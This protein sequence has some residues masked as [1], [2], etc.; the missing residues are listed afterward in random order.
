MTPDDPTSPDQPSYSVG[1]G[2]PP[3]HSRFKPG[4]SGNPRGRKKGERSVKAVVR[5]V[6]NEKVPVRTARGTRKMTKLEALVH[7]S[8]NNA[9]KGNAKATDQILKLMREAG[10][11][12]ERAEV[13]EAM[14]IDELAAEDRAIL[15]RLAGRN[16][17]PGSEGGE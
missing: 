10:L 4:Q 16:D 14:T 11:D 2:K 3:A 6:L 13:L 17:D 12:E 7:T 5:K 9:L 1:Y 15:E 8:L